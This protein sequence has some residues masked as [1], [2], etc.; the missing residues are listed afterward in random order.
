MF[1]ARIRSA[2]ADF[3]VTENIDFEL[4]GDGE[5]DF[6]WIEKSGANTAW[7]SRQLSAHAGVAANDVG[8]AGLKDRHA[9]TSQWFSVRRPTGAGTDWSAF[10]AEGVRIIETTRHLKKL[11]RGAHR[12]NAFRIALRSPAID[13]LRDE[14]SARL[15]LIEEQGVPNY[16]GEQRFG[17]DGGNIEL[18]P[19]VFAG[20]RVKRDKR[21]IAISSARSLL[22]NH[23]LDTRVR[24]RTWNKLQAGD[25]ANLDGSGSVFAVEEV[26]TDLADRCKTFDI[27]P[28]GT[29]WGD[30][31]PLTTADIAL[32]EIESVKGHQPL[33]EGL[34]KARVEASSRA[35]RMPVRDLSVD[36]DDDVLWLSFNLPKGGFATVVLREAATTS[37]DLL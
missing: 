16:F 8:Y 10:E 19:D 12:S 32:A 27:H 13:G 35:S 7:V 30:G 6:L 1:V 3:I 22:F 18:A 5:H 15:K 2:P 37:I 36:F 34:Q 24:N 9:I 31:A 23:I 20:R 26:T 25:L 14:I 17:R 4:T 29:L 11:R 28:T 21:S 33:T